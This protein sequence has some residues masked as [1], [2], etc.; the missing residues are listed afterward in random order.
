MP[1]PYD[2]PMIEILRLWSR[3]GGLVP[4]GAWPLFFLLAFWWFLLPIMK[5]AGAFQNSG[6]LP[7][8][9][10]GSFLLLSLHLTLRFFLME[11]IS[12]P[13]IALWEPESLPDGRS[14]AYQLEGEDL[15]RTQAGDQFVVLP[16]SELCPGATFPKT[17][18]AQQNLM[19]SLGV[20][21][22][23]HTRFGSSQLKW[24]QLDFRDGYLSKTQGSLPINSPTESAVAFLNAIQQSFFPDDP[25]GAVD[26]QWGTDL[27]LALFQVPGDSASW[28][29]DLMSLDENTLSP[30]QK[31]RLATILLRSSLQPKRCLALINE[32][33]ESPRPN[34]SAPFRLAAEWFIHE[35]QWENV[36]QALANG[37]GVNPFDPELYALIAQLNRSGLQEFGFPS[38]RHVLER[39]NRLLPLWPSVAIRLG[40]LQMENRFGKEACATLDFPLS[41]FPRDREL[42]LVR[43]NIAYK[44]MDFETAKTLYHSLTLDDPKLAIAWQNLGQLHFLIN[45]FEAASTHLKEA[46]RLGSSPELLHWLGRAQLETGDTLDA[47]QSFRR[48][49]AH[50]GE[51]EDLQQTARQLRLIFPDGPPVDTP[52]P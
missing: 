33:L 2:L 39:A 37:L 19:K 47:I 35:E 8:G 13:R 34:D 36:R 43:A 25:E 9:L 23:L 12:S 51:R 31:R 17:V 15:L 1:F 52:T 32:A 11:P 4:G 27:P 44:M 16:L 38:R 14:L 45:D 42:R 7:P 24:T 50:G 30:A 28:A 20:T 40:S 22:L 48:R 21:K 18:E 26:A 49:M 5:R 6:I 46:I 41:L 29:L 3:L 10:W